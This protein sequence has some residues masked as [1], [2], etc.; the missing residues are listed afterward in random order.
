M[1]SSAA[2]LI[3]AHPMAIDCTSGKPDPDLILKDIVVRSWRAALDETNN[4]DLQYANPEPAEA[5]VRHSG[6]VWSATLSPWPGQNSWSDLP[7][8]N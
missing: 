3:A 7:R 4:A 5:L 8:N 6:H 1:V 2:R